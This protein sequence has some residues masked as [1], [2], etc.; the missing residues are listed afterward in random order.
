MAVGN[1]LQMRNL[2]L[3]WILKLDQSDIFLYLKL[4]NPGV[5][6]YESLTLKYQIAAVRK[7]EIEDQI[8][9][10]KISKFID[11]ESK[12]NFAHCLILKQTNYCIPLLYG[13]PDTD[14]H[15]LQMILI[16]TVRI[17]VKNR[18]YIWE[19]IIQK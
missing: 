11:R 3:P 1:P 16:A 5:V 17:I 4:R 13:L 19:R 12:L 14:L 10:A 9:F 8:N 7:K 18:R 6:F 15:G 2:D